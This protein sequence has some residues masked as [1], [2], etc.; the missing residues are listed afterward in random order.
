M[1]RLLSNAFNSI[2]EIT[3]FRKETSRLLSKE[4]ST[5]YLKFTIETYSKLQLFWVEKACHQVS[6]GELQLTQT[7]LHFKASCCNLKI[8]RLAAK[9]CEAF[10]LF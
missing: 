4:I 8:R 5:I 9:L 6:S 1:Q 10:H 7:S 3:G 2:K